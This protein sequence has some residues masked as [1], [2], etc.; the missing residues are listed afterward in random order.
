[1][2]KIR[3]PFLALRIFLSRGNSQL[4]AAS[5]IVAL[6]IALSVPMVTRLF[7]WS[8]LAMLVAVSIALILVVHVFTHPVATNPKLL[9]WRTGLII[10][11]FLLSS[12]QFFLRH[13]TSATEALDSSFAGAAYGEAGAWLVCA[14]VIFLVMVRLGSFPFLWSGNFRF[15]WLFVAWCF[16]SSFYSPARVLAFAWL[17]KLILAVLVLQMCASGMRN[18]DDIRT[19]LL[20]T[21]CGFVLLTLLPVF[22]GIVTGQP[23]FADDGRLDYFDHPVHGSQWA[24][25]TLLLALTVFEKRVEVAS[26]WVTISAIIMVASGGKAGIIAAVMSATILLALRRNV[27]HA[28]LL[29]VGLSVIAWMV[30]SLTPV[31]HYIEDYAESGAATSL[32]GRTNLWGAAVP[33]IMQNPLLGH[34]YMSSRFISQ[35]TDLEDFNWAPSQMHNSFLEITYT[36]GIVGLILLLSLHYQIGRQLW[37]AVRSGGTLAAAGFALYVDVLLQS[38]VEGSVAGKASDNFL[39]LVALVVVSEKIAHCE[40]SADAPHFFQA[41]AL[42]RVS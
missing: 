20:A 29:V 26:V 39:L 8:D 1:M 6:A 32:T 35:S 2:I 31:S 17:F 12:E 30:L 9:T 41:G 5:V 13:M 28:L 21:F 16:V 24:G 14:L 27:R 19:F 37:T 18:R 23:A 40:K 22:H 36:G 7:E 4:L 25:I 33:M 11:A 15:L 38:W 3:N 10:W 34:G 42:A